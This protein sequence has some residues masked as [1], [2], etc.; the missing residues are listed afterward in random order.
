MRC[1]SAPDRNLILVCAYALTAAALPGPVLEPLS[2]QVDIIPGQRIRATMSNG[3][4]VTG[5]AVSITADSLTINTGG[6]ATSDQ[7]PNF[8]FYQGAAAFG[9]TVTLP[10]DR[11]VLI[12]ISRGKVSGLKKGAMYGALAGAAVGLLLGVVEMQED[13]VWN[14]CGATCV[15]WKT[16]TWSSLGAANGLW[17]GYFW[18]SGENWV[19]QYGVGAG[20][21][22]SRAGAAAFQPPSLSPRVSIG[23]RVSAG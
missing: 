17:V 11:I 14:V 1:V 12:E 16:V 7:T 20:P 19:V 4:L 8:H 23:L 3:G 5:T 2:A 6:V 18:L 10:I 15:L 21:P 9:P 22:P 13:V